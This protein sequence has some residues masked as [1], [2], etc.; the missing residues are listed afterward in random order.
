MGGRCAGILRVWGLDSE[1]EA[2][3]DGSSGKSN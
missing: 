3:A 1:E 2:L